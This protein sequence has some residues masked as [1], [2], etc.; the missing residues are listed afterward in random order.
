VVQAVVA[1]IQAS[2]SPLTGVLHAAAVFD[3]RLIANMDQDSLDKVLQTK[4]VGAW[5]LH[6]A[7]QDVRLSHFVLYSSVTTSIGNP[8]QAN[9]VAANA[10][11]EGLTRLRQ[12]LGLAASCIAWGPIGDAGYLT[13]NETVKDSLGKRLG[14]ASLQSD[15]ALDQLDR[16]LA[17]NGEVSIVANFDWNALAR[18]LASAQSE[19]FAILNRARKDQDSG[20]D[21]QDIHALIAGKTPEQIHALVAEWVAQEV[22]NIL[23]T[24]VDRIET[25]RSLHDLGMDSLMAVELALGLEQ[26]FGVQLPAMVLNDS[27][28]VWNVAARIVDKLTAGGEDSAEHD[29]GHLVADVV[30]QHGDEM[31][32][33]DLQGLA[34]D[35]QRLAETGTSLIHE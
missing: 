22:A 31:S 32:D 8:G 27:P 20:S 18:L 24:E 26:R 13:R 4:L 12:N 5:N 11:L 9:Y 19:R 16:V 6:L 28:T 35:V 33:T 3:D 15:Q 29:A 34:K 25:Q 23:R 21:G 1:Q 7:T 30:R 14:K 2:D 10:G 17:V